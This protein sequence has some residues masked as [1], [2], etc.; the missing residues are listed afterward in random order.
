MSEDCEF[1]N[2]VVIDV[3]LAQKVQE[4]DSNSTPTFS[5]LTYEAFIQLVTKHK[6][7]DSVT[8]DIIK[9]FDKFH[10][11]LTVTLPSNI[12]SAQS[13][14]DLMQIPHILYNKIVVIEY[15]QIEYTLHYRSIFDTI[16]ELLSNEEI[17]KYCTFD[18]NPKYITNNKG[19]EE[20]CYFELY[21]GEW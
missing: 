17:F 4:I 20:R 5:N 3:R 12:K 13:L 18:Y 8:N 7:F 10:M 14:L 1:Q 2:S 6:L 16:K 9:L 19:E 11:N 15:N 21:N